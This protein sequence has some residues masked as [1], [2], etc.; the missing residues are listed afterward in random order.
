MEVIV[1][2]CHSLISHLSAQENH[3]KE[4]DPSLNEEELNE[5]ANGGP[6]IPDIVCDV[7]IR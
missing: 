2:A 4:N 3:D 5:R 6:V 7:A 1:N